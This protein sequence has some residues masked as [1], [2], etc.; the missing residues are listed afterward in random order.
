MTEPATG[1]GEYREEEVTTQQA[2][3]SLVRFNASHFRQHKG[4]GEQARYS[5]PA[6][7]SRDDDLLLSRFIDQYDV[8]EAA[9]PSAAVVEAI[10]QTLE[11]AVGWAPD[12]IVPPGLFDAVRTWLASLSGGGR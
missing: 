6:D 11:L 8:L 3:D 2:R 7:P 12:R 10:G 1:K 5:I 9:A 4:M